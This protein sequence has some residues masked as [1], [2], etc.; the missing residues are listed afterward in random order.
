VKEWKKGRDELWEKGRASEGWKKERKDIGFLGLPSGGRPPTSFSSISLFFLRA[1][2]SL[3][4]WVTWL[5]Q[6]T[7]QTQVNVIH[8]S[9][10]K[11]SSLRQALSRQM[12][13]ALG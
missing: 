10:F 12:S 2:F 1:L 7:Q 5:L 13:N 6:K 4:S 3:F 11:T 9:S 8:N